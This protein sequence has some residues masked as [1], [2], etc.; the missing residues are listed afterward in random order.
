M[1]TESLALSE[2]KAR[3]SEVVRQVRASGESVV[4]TVSG[5]PAAEIR[6]IPR[7]STPSPADGAQFRALVGLIQDQMRGQGAFD[8]VE[9]VAEG[10]R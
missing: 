9:L 10:R 1:A 7:E 6:A 8:A 5:E 2:A 3:L 4:I